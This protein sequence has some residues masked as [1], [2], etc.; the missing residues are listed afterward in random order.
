MINKKKKIIIEIRGYEREKKRERA[1][2][3]P[4]ELSMSRFW[5]MGVKNEENE[6]CHKNV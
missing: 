1:S 5:K 3:V 2:C 6:N 4:E